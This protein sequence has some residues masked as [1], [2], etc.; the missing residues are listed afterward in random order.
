MENATLL[1]AH[2]QKP[3]TVLPT[4]YASYVED[5]VEQRTKKMAATIRAL[6]RSKATLSA[7]L[8][9]EKDLG[10]LKNQFLAMASHELRT[11]LSTAYLSASLIEAY[12]APVQNSP[13]GKHAG[14]IINAVSNLTAVLNNFLYVE[15]L[16]E[17]K[18]KA[19]SVSFDLV[20]LSQE[21]CEELQLLAKA[22]QQIHYHHYGEEKLVVLDVN[23]IKNCIINLLTNALKYSGESSTITFITEIKNGLCTISV[24][25]EGIGITEEEQQHLFE[26]FFR[27][28]NAA[29]VAGTGL[30][31]HIVS[32]YLTLMKGSII[33]KS[34]LN[35]GTVFTL[36]I[37]L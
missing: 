30:G 4:N 11:P 12:A 33:C 23:L 36:N 35:E 19:N 7:A 3:F 34:T 37:L 17:G 32:R 26:P 5:L 24:K 20:Q 28:R 6:E 16:E 8:E 14:K 31:L 25:D 2:L 9:K 13:I 27:A 29:N 22:N 1:T 18:I 15:R 10:V 21:I